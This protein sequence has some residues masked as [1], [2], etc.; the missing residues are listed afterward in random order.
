MSIIPPF[1]RIFKEIEDTFLPVI[2]QKGDVNIVAPRDPRLPPTRRERR[3]GHGRGHA[4]GMKSKNL[5]A[6]GLRARGG[7][8][9]TRRRGMPA[10]GAIESCNGGMGKKAIGWN[11]HGAVF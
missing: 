5:G 10:M 7:R 3:A 2:Q 6:P 9:S 4:T 8:S 11:R 1:A